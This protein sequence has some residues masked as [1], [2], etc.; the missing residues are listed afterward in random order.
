[1]EERYRLFGMQEFVINL[2]SGKDSC[3]VNPGGLHIRGP[4]DVKLLGKA[5]QKLVDKSDALRFVFSKDE[6]TGEIYQ[7]VLSS[8]KHE[9]D[10]REAQGDSYEEKLRFASEDI[11]QVMD[12][13]GFL[14]DGDV[15]WKVVLY[16]I[17]EDEHVLW[18][19]VNHII[20]DGV[21]VANAL[22]RIVM[23]Y[24][25]IP[26]PP[27]GKFL[28]YIIEQ[29]KLE[30]DPVCVKERS[31]FTRYLQS[32]NDPL[33]S[34]GIGSIEGAYHQVVSFE[35]QGLKQFAKENKMSLFH[36]ALF[37]YHAAIS[38]TFKN[39]DSLIGVAVGVRKLKYMLSIG[40]CLTGFGDRIV[41]EAEDSMK[42]KAVVCKKQYLQESKKD[43]GMYNSFKEGILF[44]MAYQNFSGGQKEIKLGKASAVPLDDYEGLISY[45]WK[46]LCF[47]VYEMEDEMAFLTGYDE[48]IFTEEIMNRMRTAFIVASECLTGEDMTFAEFCREVDRRDCGETL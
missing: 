39:G 6:E 44:S 3:V 11:K 10:I 30:T 26:I 13:V 8:Y 9:L 41:F 1:M 19:I 7:G 5:V 40:N 36:V 22:T 37:L 29:Y 12:E 33:D 15:K 4:L 28:D 45:K 18:F 23:S 42:A 14:L 24:N 46:S 17:K 38:A 34:A 48:N 31:E 35:L 47:D 27:T 32:Y 20:S 2:T 25:G 43:C 21:S 16:R